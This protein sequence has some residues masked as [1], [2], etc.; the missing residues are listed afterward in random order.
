MFC[1]FPGDLNLS[2][3][4]CDMLRSQICKV[5]VIWYQTICISMQLA[6]ISKK[7]N[8]FFKSL[9][10]QSCNLHTFTYHPVVCQLPLAALSMIPPHAGVI[11]V[12]LMC[13]FSRDWICG[14]IS[15]YLKSFVHQSTVSPKKN[16]KQELE[17][18]YAVLDLKAENGNVG[19]LENGVNHVTFGFYKS[20]PHSTGR[21]M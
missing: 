14:H 7:I 21:F 2:N 3:D 11:T 9:Q 1:H 12:I 17:W 10:E 15:V 16:P 6:N 18:N 4:H 8:L 5:Q 19:R 13:D 20:F